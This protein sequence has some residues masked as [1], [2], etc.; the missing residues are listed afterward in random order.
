MTLNEVMKDTADAIREK[1]GKSD[2]I[3]P[4]DFAEEIKGISAGGGS[5]ESGD[6]GWEYYKVDSSFN[7]LKEEELSTIAN[8]V[9]GMLSLC[10]MGCITDG[11]L[12]PQPWFGYGAKLQGFKV[13]GE[14]AYWE[15]LNSGGLNS[16]KD[17]TKEPFLSEFGTTPLL[18]LTNA[19]TPC[20]KEEFYALK[21][22]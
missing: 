21:T 1:T 3:K 13:F 4:I 15:M 17:L 5:G 20:T 2:L 19:L 8:G 7:T 14:G 10:Y 11:T 9:K 18:P 22:K 16:F 6:D 12:L